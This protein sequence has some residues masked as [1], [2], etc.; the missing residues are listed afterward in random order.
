MAA[1]QCR[2]VGGADRFFEVKTGQRI[3]LK[4]LFNTNNRD[5]DNTNKIMAFDVIDDAFDRN[6]PTAGTIPQLLNPGNVVMALAATSGMKVRNIRVERND[7]TNEWNLNGETWHEVVDS[8]FRKVL[9][10]PGLGDTEIWEIENKSGGWFHPVHIHLIDFKILSRNGK[11]PFAYELGPKDV[12]YVG[13]GEKVR[14]IMKIR[15]APR[16]LHGALP[17]PAARGPRHDAPVQRGPEGR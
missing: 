9:A 3:E 2:T 14:L 1:R 6:D 13:E 8:G 5:F 11:A 4:N 10:D 17:Q 15:S 7:S 12:V 16:E